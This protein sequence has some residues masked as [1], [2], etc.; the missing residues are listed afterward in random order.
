[1]D[2]IITLTDTFL[3]LA[4]GG[5]IKEYQKKIKMMLNGATLHNSIKNVKDYRQKQKASLNKVR[6]LKLQQ[7]QFMIDYW[8][9]VLESIGEGWRR[10]S[11]K[12][13]SKYRI[14]TSMKLFK[15]AINIVFEMLPLFEYGYSTSSLIL[16]RSLYET[17][18]ISLY[19]INSN[20]IIS[21]Q[22]N[23]YENVS[24]SSFCK[25]S[26]EV[27]KARQDIINQYPPDFKKSYGWTLQ[28]GNMLDSFNQIRKSVDESK[29]LD[30]YKLSCEIVHASS[31]SVNT[32]SSD[33]TN[34]N[35]KT[36]KAFTWENVF[37]LVIELMGIYS[38]ILVKTYIKDSHISSALISSTVILIK[39]VMIKT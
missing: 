27:P 12:D 24:I 15:K 23:D 1:M 30:W 38:T 20:E 37:D 21:K 33:T 25:N 2:K 11:N 13:S 8:S 4:T 34:A 3:E 5:D 17:Y 6:A 14:N 29:F 31:I 19:L 9:Q 18:V 7:Y 16:W 36:H 10:D 35:K 26:N 39:T 22:F 32:F 28:N